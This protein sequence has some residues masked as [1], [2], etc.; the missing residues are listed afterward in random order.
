MPASTDLR[1]EAAAGAPDPPAPVR[2]RRPKWW[3][4]AAGLVAVCALLLAANLRATPT[5]KTTAADVN[6]IVDRKVADALKA[7][8][9]Q[10]PDSVTV[11]DAIRPPLVLIQTQRSGGRGGTDS[12]LGSGV[13]V[14]AQGDI[15]TSLHVVD[16]ASTIKVSFSDG[17][18]SPASVKSTD[19]DHDIA[20]LAPRWSRRRCWAAVPRSATRRSPSG[21]P[22]GWWDRC[23]RA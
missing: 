13:I 6:G 18:E 2:R 11:Y 20:V 19:P 15:L 22:S 3:F 14:N 8:Q 12:A 4:G 17:T 16:G 7:L 1:V 23:R 9:A 10:P 21:I 5:P